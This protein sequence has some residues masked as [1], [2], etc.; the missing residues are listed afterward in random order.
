M[1]TSNV[2]VVG[3]ESAGPSSCG[4]LARTT[5]RWEGLGSQFRA[6]KNGVLLGPQVGW[7]FE[8]AQAAGGVFANRRL[9]AGIVRRS[10]PRLEIQKI[11]SF[12]HRS[13]RATT[14]DL[15]IR[16]R[17]SYLAVSK[18][19]LQPGLARLPM[20]SAVMPRALF[21]VRPT[22]NHAETQ[23]TIRKAIEKGEPAMVAR[24]GQSELR[25]V[26]DFDLISRWTGPKKFF[27]AVLLLR[28][29]RWFA[30]KFQYLSVPAG[31]FPTSE[32]AAMRRFSETMRS[33]A[34]WVDLL[35]SWVPGESLIEEFPGSMKVTR[36]GY[37]DPIFAEAPWT[38][39]LAGKRVLVVHPFNETIAAQYEK[40]SLLFPDP[41]FL[42]D[43]HLEVLGVPQTI[44][45]GKDF[46]HLGWRDWFEA[47]ESVKQQISERD[48]DVAIIGAGA[49]GLPLAAHVK[50]L[51]RVAIHLGGHTQLLFGII[52]RRWEHDP[53]LQQIR[54]RHWTRPSLRETP[55]LA[56]QAED[57]AYW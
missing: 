32:F 10:P 41:N 33:S 55:A 19:V 27:S 39:E 15:K 36:L 23:E 26:N 50:Q 8:P 17:R 13:W 45:D 4:G 1:W 31:F 37:L 18:R 2:F 44:N 30:E 35:G 56:I 48:F 28:G 11:M 43:F 12:K 20:F 51:G 7:H 38:S 47:L 3:Q 53:Q 22:L 29:T 42:P 5:E 16:A 49:Y 57:K 24:F 34:C 52:G 54:N 46:S 9:C 14:Q 40:R 6:P 25:A 21:E